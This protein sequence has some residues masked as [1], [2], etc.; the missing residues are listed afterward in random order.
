[1]KYFELLSNTS[2][3][4]FL[5]ISGLCIWYLIDS[6][7]II[8]FILIELAFIK[9]FNHWFNLFKSQKLF[10]LFPVIL[11]FLSCSKNEDPFLDDNDNN[12]I[13]E[14]VYPNSDLN[15]YSSIN[16]TTSWY[17]TNKSFDQ[18][19]SVSNGNFRAFELKSDGN[20]DPFVEG[21]WDRNKVDCC[22]YWH[23]LGQYLYTDL[24][25]DGN[26]DLW[27]YYWKSPWP[28]N[29]NGLHLYIDNFE[30]YESYNLQIGLTQVRK[31]V[32]SDF[33]NDNKPEITLFSS[34][35]DGNP[36]PGD[37]L[38][39]FNVENKKYKYLSDDIGY[40]HGGATGDINKDGFEDIVAYSGG[41]AVIPVHPVYYENKGSEN[42]IL[43]NDIFL[44]F[45]DSDNYYT[46]ELFD[47]D[48]D[49]LLDLFLGSTGK[50]LIIKNENGTFNRLNG[51]NIQ[52][53]INLEVMDI[54]FFDF[55]NDNIKEIIVMNN[56]SSYQGYSLNVYKFSFESNSHITSDY[57][58]ETKFE[59]NNA[60][61]KWIHIFDFDK[62]GDLDIVGDGL[63]GD[64]VNSN[65]HWN[66]EGG[67]FKKRI[68][69]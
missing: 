49:G 30:N 21:T 10:I 19:L 24:N 60:W 17:R 52:S 45:N 58:E 65:I 12:D 35:Y 20:I 48:N 33:D 3:V 66:N 8:L 6:E 27:S 36:F 32:I 13:I 62:D 39:I 41:S 59:G 2:I 23:D 34:G 63:F 1:M 29:A 51:I 53:D 42:F 14:L 67:K 4:L 43:K 57:F 15:N 40:F 46:V 37:S 69:N 47:I 26:K 55:D 18:L 28:T 50:L 61:I 7:Y 5:L 16:K 25:G 38:A 68:T 22:Y 54:D 56:F 64:I 11:F 31:N 44:N 9:R